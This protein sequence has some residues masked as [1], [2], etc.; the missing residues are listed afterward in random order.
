[1]LQSASF[2]EKALPV[3][4]SWGE[5]LEKEV[6]IIPPSFH[7][8]RRGTAAAHRACSGTWLMLMGHSLGA[9]FYAGH[10]RVVD[11]AGQ[12]PCPLALTFWGERTI[13]KI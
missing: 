10:R 5:V 7:Q 1:M 11:K 8:E 9:R 13:K 3:P 12:H 2:T 6:L 4:G